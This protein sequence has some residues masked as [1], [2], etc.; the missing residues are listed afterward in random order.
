MKRYKLPLG[1]RH[2]FYNDSLRVSV[3]G[4]ALAMGDTSGNKTASARWP[5]IPGR[6]IG[7]HLYNVTELL[8]TKC[9]VKIKHINKQDIHQR[10]CL[11][12]VPM[13]GQY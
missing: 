1:T 10:G 4:A 2:S 3:A 7:K 6:E 13:R 12:K 8:V 5:D 9:S 11:R